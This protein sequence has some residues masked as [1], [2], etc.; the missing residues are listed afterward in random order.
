MNT[1]NGKLEKKIFIKGRIITKSGL[2]IGGS[3]LRYSIGGTDATVVRNPLNNE[4]YI[5]GSSL[6]GKMRSLLEKSEG[7]FTKG[8]VPNGPYTSDVTD[9]ICKVFG[10]SPNDIDKS[11]KKD[12]NLSSVG[13][14]IVRDSPLSI[15]SVKKT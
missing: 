4:P 5:P 3:N 6:K 15:G 2:H 1:T 10:F 8:A 14:I 11:S 9:L 7:K 12:E 13:R